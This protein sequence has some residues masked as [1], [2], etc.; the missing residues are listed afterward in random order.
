MTLKT[1][2]AMAAAGLWLALDTV[3]GL[4]VV[5]TISLGTV[6]ALQ[7]SELLVIETLLR[8]HPGRS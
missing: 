4:P 6:F 8:M 5:S 1:L 2:I 7:Y 3:S